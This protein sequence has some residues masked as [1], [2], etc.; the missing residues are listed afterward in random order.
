MHALPGD[1]R[2]LQRLYAARGPS[3]PTRHDMHRT[4]LAMQ[5]TTEGDLAEAERRG[6]DLVMRS[7]T[8]EHRAGAATPQPQRQGRR[9]VRAG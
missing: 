4:G 5:H 3:Y 7:C 1:D 6:K 9:L 8:A 2:R